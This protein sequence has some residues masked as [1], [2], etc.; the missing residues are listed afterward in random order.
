MFAGL[1]GWHVL[2]PLAILVVPIVLIVIFVRRA[3]RARTTGDTSP[4]VSLT[5]SL[6]AIWAAV[7][8]I[9]AAI[10]FVVA[11]AGTPTITIPVNQYW[12]TVPGL[13]VDSGPTA[14][15]VSG[16]FTQA[17][18]TVEGLSPQTRW[19]WA[20]GQLL[21]GLVPVAIAGMIAVACFQLL[22]GR[23]FAPAV[24]RLSL[25]TGIVVAVAGC[26]G[27]L[28]SGIGGS[29]AAN[30]LLNVVSAHGTVIP[31]ID[32]PLSLLPTTSLDWSLPL[33]P[34]AAGL[35]FAALAA[36]FRYGSV[37]QRD[38]QGLV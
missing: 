22:A 23:A 19:T 21:T 15:Y 1:F 18:V 10:A 26:A 11:L 4:V 20:A 16:G 25:V 38:T 33:W 14:S 37:L 28:L 24:A 2:I 12:P 5:L 27:E 9:G 6:A 13:T 7:S 29:M 31:G 17:E 34:I 32:D 30:E 8:L 35:A 3:R 36:I